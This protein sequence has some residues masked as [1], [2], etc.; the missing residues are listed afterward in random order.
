VES[1]G[2]TTRPGSTVSFRETSWIL[3]LFIFFS[4]IHGFCPWPCWMKMVEKVTWSFL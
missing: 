3:L 1:D 4:S 2:T